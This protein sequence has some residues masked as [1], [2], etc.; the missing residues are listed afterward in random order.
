MYPSTVF[1]G[2]AIFVSVRFPMLHLGHVINA[3]VSISVACKRLKRF[4]TLPNR[5]ETIPLAPDSEVLAE[6]KNVTIG[7]DDE[8]KPVLKAGYKYSRK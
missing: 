3:L 6:L 5:D 4:L 8:S 2:V 1:G 7:W